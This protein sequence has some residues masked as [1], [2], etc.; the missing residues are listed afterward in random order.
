MIKLINPNSYI[1]AIRFFWWRALIPLVIKSKKVALAKNVRF[2]GCPLISSS[3]DFSIEIGENCV[4]CSSSRMTALGVNHPVILRTLTPGAKIVIGK[5]VGISGATICASSYIEIGDECLL[6]A[7]VIVL[8]TDFHTV[9]PLRRRFN[10]D[11]AEIGS[12]RTII[13]RNV[14]VGANAII[15]KGVRVGE[16]SVIGAGSVVVTDVPPNTVFGGNPAKRISN[17]DSHGGYEN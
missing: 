14:F 17:L 2:Y 11:W 5:N 1:K 12:K 8:D 15:L 9:Q 4:I 10:A 16:N 3:T 7:N 13:E 6:G